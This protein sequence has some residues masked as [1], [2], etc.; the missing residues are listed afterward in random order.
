MVGEVLL[1]MVVVAS[2]MSQTVEPAKLA[3]ACQGHTQHLQAD[4]QSLPVSLG[5]IVNLADRIVQGFPSAL[6]Y[7]LVDAAR[8]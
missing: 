8:L 5:I 7:A 4:S 1:G 2:T 6:V 3:L